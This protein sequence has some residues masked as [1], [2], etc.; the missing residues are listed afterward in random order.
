MNNSIQT[1]HKTPLELFV[2]FDWIAVKL[3]SLLF[4]LLL[5]NKDDNKV[6]F[7]LYTRE[8]IN[9]EYQSYDAEKIT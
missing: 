4:I 7:C 6:Y 8:E 2:L 3:C 5:Y 1:M 9:E